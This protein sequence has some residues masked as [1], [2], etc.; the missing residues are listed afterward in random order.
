MDTLLIATTSRTTISAP[1]TVQI[2]IPPL[3]HPYAWFIIEPLPFGYDQAIPT[4]LAREEN[5]FSSGRSW[6]CAV[7]PNATDRVECSVSLDLAAATVVALRRSRRLVQ[8]LLRT[9]IEF[10]FALGT[11][12]VI[13]LPFMLGSSSGSSAF[14]VHATDRIFHSCC[15]IHYDLP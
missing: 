3:I 13:G 6:R 15:A 9:K 4:D 10:L 11:A 1:I 2:H 8:V 12:E 14:Y 5:G 7:Y